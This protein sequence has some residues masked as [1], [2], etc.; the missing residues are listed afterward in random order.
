RLICATH[1]KLPEMVDQGKFRQDLYY[2]LNVVQLHLP[3]LRERR[4]DVPLLAQEFL[5][6]SAQQF[7]KRARRFSQQA[8]HSLEEYQWPGN[9]RELEN[10]IQRAVALSEEQTVDLSHLPSPLRKAANPGPAAAYGCE[11]P[12]P[13]RTYEEEIRC[14]KRG[15]VLR[16]LRE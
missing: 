5:Q 13:P 9:V 4:D 3:P 14:F 11:T 1:Q 12:Q 16:T 6:K 8:L 15:L 10:V 7:R 2:R